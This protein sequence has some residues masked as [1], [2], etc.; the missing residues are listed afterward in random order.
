MILQTSA[1]IQLPQ[2]ISFS[3][4]I[5]QRKN[6]NQ[7]RIGVLL[8]MQYADGVGYSDLHPWPELGDP[9]IK[10]LFDQLK[11]FV[12]QKN[13]FGALSPILKQSL[14]FAEWDALARKNKKFL[15]QDAQIPKSH[16]L[17]Y[18]ENQI[19]EEHL[20]YF[21]EQ[22]FDYLKVKVGG[23]PLDA[24][25]SLSYLTSLLSILNEEYQSQLKLRLDVNANWTLEQFVFFLNHFDVKLRQ[26]ID[27]IEDPFITDTVDTANMWSPIAQNEGLRLAV[28]FVEHPELIPGES[29]QVQIVKPAVD[30][31][32][33]L[34]SNPNLSYVVTSYLGHPLGQNQ[35]A[36]AAQTLN[37]KI[38]L[39]QAGLLSH[40]LYHENQFS[41]K[42]SAQGA[43]YSTDQFHEDSGLGFDH[44]LG[45]LVWKSVNV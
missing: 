26:N 6:S 24:A 42:L 11:N 1:P 29:Y 16:F 21:I 3:N 37:S 43:Q 23:D 27:F 33:K 4:Y 25:V 13:S 32:E 44:E 9:Y 19:E 31:F 10:T 12:N 7:S 15:L 22:G 17:V 20:R 2:Q 39:E 41:K 30:D 34:T 36:F 38:K 8:K 5:L 18:L 35:A 14:K 45:R 40:H 28:D